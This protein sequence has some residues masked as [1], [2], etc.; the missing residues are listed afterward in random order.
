MLLTTSCALHRMRSVE[1]EIDVGNDSENRKD[2]WNALV[3]YAARII[4]YLKG[5]K[6]SDRE[7]TLWKKKLRKIRLSLGVSGNDQ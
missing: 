6:L 1:R 2:E 4:R 7:R 5:I 3:A